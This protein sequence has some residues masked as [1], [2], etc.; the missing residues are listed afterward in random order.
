MLPSESKQ[1]ARE[2]RCRLQRAP[3]PARGS[4][5]GLAQRGDASR[6]RDSQHPSRLWPEAPSSPARQMPGY[7]APE[8]RPRA[9]E[10]G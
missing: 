6:P 1:G 8:Q 7:L 3:A 5:G 10:E 9:S 4:V 2:G